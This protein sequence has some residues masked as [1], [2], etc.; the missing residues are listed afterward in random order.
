[1]RV[2]V[3]GEDAPGA[4][5][6]SYVRG[7]RELGAEVDGYCL[8][9]AYREA[10]PGARHRIRGRLVKP[11]GPRRFNAELLRRMRERHSDLALVLKGH[12]IAPGTIESLRKE[13]GC[14]IVNFYPDDPFTNAR[15]NRLT[16][17]TETL[18]AYDRCYTFARHLIEDYRGAGVERVEYLPFARDPEFHAP[19]PGRLTPRFD[20]IFVGNLDSE[21]IRWLEPVADYRIAIAGVHTRQ[22]LS[23]RSPL[24]R[25]VFLPPAYGR[26]FS[27]MV[28]QAPV[29]LN[30]MREQNRASHNMRSYEL[31]AC[32]A[33]TLTQRT[34]ELLDLFEEG[35]QVACFGDAL[36]L[37][38]QLDYWLANTERRQ[39]VA[40]AGFRRVQHD[41]YTKRAAAILD[42]CRGSLHVQ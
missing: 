26:D 41:T 39:Q 40:Q 6:H 36:E 23:G 37:R 7:F 14:P 25:A 11:L 24:Q 12:H 8:Q 29:A 17:G 21:R 20:A 18:A 38:A 35:A 16:F 9:R 34:P 10:T 4:L 15:Q 31:P 13:L 5:L 32:R 27:R 1:M 30:I 28:A 19:F 42:D 22:A 33:F 3:L 2:L